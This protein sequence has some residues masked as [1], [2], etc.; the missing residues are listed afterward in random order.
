MNE[1][2]N[3][4]GIAIDPR[5]E[6]EKSKDYQASDILGGS[7]TDIV[8]EEKKDWTKLSLR[9]QITSSSCGAQ[10][11]ARVIESFN[12]DIM[13]ATPLYR[14]RSNFSG[15]G[16]FAKDIGEIGKNKKTTTEALSPSQNMTEA[17]M[18][19]APIPDVR[20]F[21]IAGY[22]F[23]PIN[24]DL[25]ATALEKGHGIIFGI[26]ANIEEWTSH[27]KHTGLRP[28]FNHYV[29]C[30]DK[31]YTLYNGEK[32]FIIDDSVNAYS[33]ING[34]GQRILTE[35]FLRK[36]AW[37][38][39]AFIPETKV[40][41]PVHTFT[42]NMVFGDRGNEVTMLQR[43]LIDQGLLKAGLDTGYFGGLTLKAVRAFQEKYRKDILVPAGTTTATGKVLKF[44]RN[45]LN[46]LY[47][48]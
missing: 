38:V 31:N 37:T 23:L 47:S 44:T 4:N 43:C 5:T 9:R 21:G 8:W 12:K 46:E 34:S 36:R 22:Y 32:S 25:I 6:E 1:L 39:M 16:M 19:S 13:S 14:F 18:N 30:V 3:Y 2:E 41:K 45:K 40:E 29:A 11:I 17:Q 20:P 28:T 33:T 35:D 27:P 7:V 15:E 26:G 42:K 48:K 10:S 24:P